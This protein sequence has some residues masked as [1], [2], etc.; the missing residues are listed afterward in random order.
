LFLLFEV[1]QQTKSEL[2]EFSEAFLQ[3]SLQNPLKIDRVY[4]FEVFYVG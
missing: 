1:W 2:R 3:R 4:F